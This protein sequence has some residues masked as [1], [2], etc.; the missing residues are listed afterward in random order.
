M[1]LY[2][3]FFRVFQF[4]SIHF[5]QFSYL[6]LSGCKKTVGYGV[7]KRSPSQGKS[8]RIVGILFK[9]RLLEHGESFLSDWWRERESQADFGSVFCPAIYQL[10]GF[11]RSAFSFLCLVFLSVNQSWCVYLSMLLWVLREN[12]LGCDRKSSQF[13]YLWIMR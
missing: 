3:N 1:S 13:P 12:M 6:W 2:G 5:T 10:R 4:C 8:G 7:S 11:Y 9:L